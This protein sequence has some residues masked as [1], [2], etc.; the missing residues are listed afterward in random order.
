MSTFWWAGQ[1]SQFG[2]DKLSHRTPL[3]SRRDVAKYCTCAAWRNKWRRHRVNPHSGRMSSLNDLR[4]RLAA[5]ARRLICS[6]Q[7]RACTC[8]SKRPRADLCELVVS[9]TMS[10]K[11]HIPNGTAHLGH[12][13]R[14]NV[15]QRVF[16][17][18]PF[19]SVAM[20]PGR[21]REET[22]RRHRGDTEG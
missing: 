10:L 19:S 21:S 15:Y 11:L 16:G 12:C 8:A 2:I 5:H 13:P 7:F 6:I 17:R 20:Q 1:R 18:R 4:K 14:C 9:S 3:M 22:Q